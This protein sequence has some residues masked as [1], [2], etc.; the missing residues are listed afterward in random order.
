[1]TTKNSVTDVNASAIEDLRKEFGQDIIVLG[2]HYQQQSIIDH[3]DFTG[4]SL[5]LARKIPDI[6]AKNIVFCGVSF[7]GESAALLAREEQSVFLPEPSAD[8]MMAL[9][10]PGKR[11]ESVLS[12]LTASGRKL[13]PLAYVNTF[14]DT[15]AVV[16]RYNGSVCTSANAATMLKWALDAGDGVLFLPD[17]NLGKNTAKKLGLKDS[18][19]CEINVDHLGKSLDLEAATKAKLLLWPGFCGI[20]A[21][22]TS[23][24]VVA[25]RSADPNAK[26]IVHPECTPEV[27]D[28]VDAAGSTSFIIKYVQSAP[29]GTHIYIGTEINLVRRLEREQASRLH[30]EPLV[31]SACLHMAKVT[32]AKLRR[33]LEQVQKGNGKKVIIPQQDIEPA[34]VTLERMLHVCK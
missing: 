13:I 16:G 31:P 29:D 23:E 17:K 27:V 7:M 4:D 24:H 15:K 12:K 20:H 10:S 14:V 19:I 6:V 32:P 25:A 9:M 21:K 11:V 5:E 3:C 30:I 1:M 22:F 33:V 18:E 2:H 8:C 26:I 28:R 34:R